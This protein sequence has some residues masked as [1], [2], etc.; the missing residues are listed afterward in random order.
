MK[1]LPCIVPF[2]SAIWL[3]LDVDTMNSSKILAAVAVLLLT[4]PVLVATPPQTS[5][6]P[7]VSLLSQ[8]D[9]RSVILMIGDGMGYEHAELASLV[10][11]GVEGSLALQSLP[12]NA[13]VVT[14][15]L[16]ALIT[17][18]AAAGTAMATGNKTNK[19][20]LAM[21][22][23]GEILQTILEIAQIANKSTGLVTTTFI[24]HA[25]PAAFMTHVMNRGQYYEIA[26]QTVYAGVD[27]LLGGGSLYFSESQLSTMVSN[28]YSLAYNRTAMLNVTS[29]R[30]LGLFESTYMEEERYRNYVTTPSL[31]EMTNKSIE[32]LSQDEDGFFLMVEGGQIDTLA[33]DNDKIGVALE[34]IEF[35]K[36]VALAL[37][38]V[39]HNPDTI[40][41]VT[42]D[43]ETG[44]LAI[45]GHGLDDNLPGDLSSESE[46]R[47][48][49][50]ERATNVTVTWQSDDHTATH[51]GLFCYGSAFDEL[52]E[53]TLIDNTNIFTLMA[54][55]FAGEP[56]S[57]E[58]LTST[59]TTGTS[60]S[61]TSPP[62][63][64]TGTS[65]GATDSN[66][67]LYLAV[68]LGAVALIVVVSVIRRR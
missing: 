64:T 7:H 19:G 60:S 1:S 51:V 65:G 26:N 46:R 34:T 31:L 36:A 11:Y 14:S 41:I 17:D 25:T 4:A 21:T 5:E 42:A 13:S 27:V 66:L 9:G 58:D 38:Y 12:W 8:I 30:L 22:P 68:G 55:F 59:T 35:D 24:Q 43:H 50:I 61:T 63:S 54:D 29:G 15:C 56:L 37:D 45:V 3:G 48:L 28:G 40:L 20:I 10:E 39:E 18:S 67:V 33:H 53:G 57:I 6:E 62:T 23:T 47:D 44:G 2:I 32:L 16:N 52:E 49:R